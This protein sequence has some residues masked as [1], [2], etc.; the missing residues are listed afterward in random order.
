MINKVDA[1]NLNDLVAVLPQSLVLLSTARAK[2]STLKRNVNKSTSSAA[3]VV[4]P[5]SRI[6]PEP[7]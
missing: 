7:G 2:L 3:L 6:A 4:R 1:A 5:C